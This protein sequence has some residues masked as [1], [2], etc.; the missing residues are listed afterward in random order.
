[1]VNRTASSDGR[2]QAVQPQ[3]HRI[4]AQIASAAAVLVRT[5]PSVR[6]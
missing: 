4:D 1:M 3:K 5:S 6:V 2:H